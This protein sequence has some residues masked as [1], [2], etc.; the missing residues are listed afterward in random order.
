MPDC[1][2]NCD[3]CDAPGGEYLV[4]LRSQNGR[5]QLV[6]ENNV[7][8]FHKRSEYADMVFCSM[9]EIQHISVY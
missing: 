3:H 9:P 4:C 7:C 1:C 2:F 6:K 5:I 8:H